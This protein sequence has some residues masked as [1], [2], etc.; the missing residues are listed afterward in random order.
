LDKGA[1]K[2]VFVLAFRFYT[3]S[4]IP[5]R[6]NHL[7]PQSSYSLHITLMLQNVAFESFVK[8]VSLSLSLSLSVPLVEFGR[9]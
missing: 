8:W 9:L 5:A 3:V 7:T 2:L 1:L 4:I 6:R